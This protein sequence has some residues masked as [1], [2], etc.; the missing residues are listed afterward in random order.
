MS[1][2]NIGLDILL[3]ELKN[4]IV[5]EDEIS[6]DLILAIKKKFPSVTNQEARDIYAL[7]SDAFN[8]QAKENASLVLTAPPSFSL[9]ARLPAIFPV[10]SES[11]II[12]YPAVAL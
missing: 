9:K 5:A 3:D 7:V 1:T 11:F 4:S 12:I 10:F 8:S 6:K 2:G